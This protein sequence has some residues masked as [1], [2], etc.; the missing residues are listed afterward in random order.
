VVPLYLLKI[1]DKS[2]LWVE[3]LC[4]TFIKESHLSIVVIDERTSRFNK[5]IVRGDKRIVFINFFI[6]FIPILWLHRVNFL[7]ESVERCLEGFGL[8]FV[9][10]D[11]LLDKW[12]D[13]GA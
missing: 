11:G 2:Y 12:I 8:L 5:L 7:A 3:L 1:P 10:F 6:V 13:T 9:A 4:N